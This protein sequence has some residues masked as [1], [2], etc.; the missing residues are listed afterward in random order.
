MTGKTV[1]LIGLVLAM[2]VLAI[3]VLGVAAPGLGGTGEA[4]A[5]A[6]GF[7]WSTPAPVEPGPE[8]ASATALPPVLEPAFEWVSEGV[9]CQRL[10]SGW[11]TCSV[12]A[13]DS[14]WDWATGTLSCDYYAHP[15]L[16]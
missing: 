9:N 14:F 11:T 15:P 2:G 1:G 10:S 5:S 6:L 7:E 12:C 8:L 16:G 3:G 13:Y 4:E